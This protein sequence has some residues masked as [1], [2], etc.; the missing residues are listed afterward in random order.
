MGG[1]VRNMVSATEGGCRMDRTGVRF[2]GVLRRAMAGLAGVVL[3]ASCVSPG[4]PSGSAGGFTFVQICDPQLGF[5]EY[6]RD[7]ASLRQAVLQV[8]GLRPDFV[9]V[10]GDMVNDANA[11][12]FSDFKAIAGELAMPYYCV[13]GN[14]DVGNRPSASSL[15][16]YRETIGR[17]YYVIEHRGAA[18]VFV[19]TQ[20][21][22]EAVAGETEKQDAWLRERLAEA[23]EK[24]QQIFIVGH[25]PLFNREA[26]EADEYMNLPIERRTELLGLFERYGAAAY[27]GGH[28]HRL[29]LNEYKGIQMVHGETTSKHF[30]ARPLGFRLWRVHAPMRPE[31]EFVPLETAGP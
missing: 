29:I 20:L 23:A 31:H 15:A 28:A 9:V 17:D 24:G 19:N 11:R 13:P 21:W 7:A 18:F 16:R 8:N 5:S 12:S 25:I 14:H 30:D 4:R 27:L 6:E 10:C 1:V 22:K 2:W 3:L 26:D